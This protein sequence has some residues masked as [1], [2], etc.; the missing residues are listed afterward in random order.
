MTT[1][2]E[3][4]GGWPAILGALQAGHDLTAA[5]TKAVLA[6]VLAG[7]AEDSQIA[8]FIVAIRMKGETVEE[9]TGMVEAMHAEAT[10]L[11][12]APDAI[13]IVGMGGAPSRR[14][15][16]LNVSTMA[17]FVAAAAGA[18]VLKHGNRKA[19]STSGSF[20]FLEALGAQFEF[21][22]DHLQKVV[23]ETGVGFA[24][25]KLYH[26]S[27]RH[28]GPVRVQLGVPTVFNAL[29]PLAN[30]ARVTRQVVGVADADLG[31]RMLGVLAATGSEF[32]WIVTGDG[33]L[34]ELS[35]T[36][37]T[38]VHQLDHGQ[39]SRFTIDPQDHG[40]APPADGALDGGDAAANTAIFDRML[41]GETGAARDIVVLN[42]AAGLVVAGVATDI[43]DGITR[44][45]A[46]LD[47]G[48]ARATVD[49][50]VQATAAG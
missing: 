29:G 4:A 10:P 23:A 43:G 3:T 28:V 21:G 2:F 24:F 49:A 25:A 6:E 34:D 9:L 14:R 50:H 5:Q 19:S 12:V 46:A 16:A 22:A 13:D 39:I 11:S 17:C 42:A 15:A 38:V 40:I 32:S 37:P 48:E 27:M 30:P 41:A 47:S 36:G 26:P 18:T 1:D 31:E 45:G 8:A 20:D 33:Q 44:A 35:T 7:R